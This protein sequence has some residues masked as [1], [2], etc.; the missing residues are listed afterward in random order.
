MFM[1]TR[2]LVAVTCWLIAT[3]GAAML[4]YEIRRGGIVLTY[5]AASCLLR[6]WSGIPC[7]GCGLTHALVDLVR[8]EWRAALSWHPLAPFVALEFAAVWLAVGAWTA[9][10]RPSRES[11][12]FAERVILFNAALFLVVWGGRLYFHAIPV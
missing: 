10:W 4:L 11:E 8:G 5:A 3:A 7:P 9:G 1:P 6:R 12:R 2:R